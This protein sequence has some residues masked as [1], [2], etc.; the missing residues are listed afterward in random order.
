M[1]P[2]S[3]TLHH[4][5]KTFGYTSIKQHIQDPQDGSSGV[6]NWLPL[7]QKVF[8]FLFFI[9]LMKAVGHGRQIRPHLFAASP[10]NR[11]QSKFVMTIEIIKLKLWLVT[12][13]ETKVRAEFSSHP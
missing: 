2:I 11:P 10:A 3:Q 4:I 5:M 7:L 9:I 1:Q 12:V 8:S 6:L 13:C